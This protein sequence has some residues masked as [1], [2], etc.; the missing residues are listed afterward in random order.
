M[1]NEQYQCIIADPGW[2]YD[3][4]MAAMKSTGNGAA[5]QYRCMPFEKICT[6]LT[7]TPSVDIEPTQSCGGG[8][9]L[10]DRIAPN[11]HL[12]LW[13][14]NP[15][16]VLGY[17]AWLCD[18]WGFVPKTLVTWVKGRMVVRA[19][20]QRVFSEIIHDPAEDELLVEP[21]LVQHYAQGRY[22]RGTT[23]HVIIAV[24]GSL[25]ALVHD[26]PSAFVHP[27]RWPGRKHSEKPPT[28]HEWAERLSPGPRIELFA[29]SFRAG[30][31]AVGDELPIDAGG[32]IVVP[33]GARE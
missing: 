28:I 24:R 15:F 18:R 30:W 14:T 20:G 5:S 13:I 25:P 3:D 26:L 31:D 2:L 33:E 1:A 10:A 23:E 16:L 9:T 7:D 19:R 27:G 4:K 32:K 11:A 12:W 29:R 21:D 8:E 6:F 17:G 22:T